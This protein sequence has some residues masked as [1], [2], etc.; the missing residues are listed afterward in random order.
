MPPDTPSLY[1]GKTALP[2]IE[3]FFQQGM[4]QFNGHSFPKPDPLPHWR[5]AH[6]SAS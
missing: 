1:N 6:S 4:K 2:F 5:L 3:P